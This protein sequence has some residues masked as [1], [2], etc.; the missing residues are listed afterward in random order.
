MSQIISI[1]NPFDTIQTTPLNISGLETVGAMDLKLALE[2]SELE[3]GL[4]ERIA[5]IGSAATL[6]VWREV[7]R[8]RRANM[9]MHRPDWS[10][11][12]KWAG[13]MGLAAEIDQEHIAGIGF[14]KKLRK[15]ISKAVNSAG[16]TVART[17]RAVRQSNLIKKVA[18]GVKA[19]GKFAIKTTVAA[20]KAFIKV[21]TLPAR[22][23]VKGLAEV[24]LPRISRLFLYLF[25]TNPATIASLPANVQRKR[26]KAER[27]AK[28][29][30]NVVGMKES[31][32]MKIVRNG[33]IKQTK[34]TPEQLLS[35]HVKGALSGI[36]FAPLIALI[37]QIIALIGKVA[38]LFKKKP[39]ADETPTA[40]DLPDENKD[41]NDA[42]TPVRR[43]VLSHLR[44]KP[45]SQQGYQ[46]APPA[47]EAR[48]RHQ[49][50]TARY[51]VEAEPENTPLEAP[52]PRPR[53]VRSYQPDV[54][55]QAEYDGENGEILSYEP[56]PGYDPTANALPPLEE[57]A[58]EPQY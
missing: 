20:T 58:Q 16:S 47:E 35:S 5:G 51:Q 12:Q 46:P 38:S 21:A 30:I 36:G 39:T 26:A 31:H 40:E 9:M 4:S 42:P 57:E 15:K 56:E 54:T 11:R 6:G 53:P 49:E 55:A 7:E 23:F 41:F 44:Y 10:P 48:E 17:V 25:I 34:Q 13:L 37:P 14:L 32:F 50:A 22:L 19:A 27:F 43:K 24:I 3:H 45:A 18:K 28:F 29:L 52:L 2:H 8:Y 33:I 1:G